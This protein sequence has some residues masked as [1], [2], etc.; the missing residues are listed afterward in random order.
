MVAQLIAISV[1]VF[2]AAKFG[3]VVE[4]KQVI[5]EE[6]RPPNGMIFMGVERC[7][8]EELEPLKTQA[9]IMDVRQQGMVTDINEIKIAVKEIASNGP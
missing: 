6:L 9:T 4:S 5:K 8:K 1:V 3:V 2:A 7:V